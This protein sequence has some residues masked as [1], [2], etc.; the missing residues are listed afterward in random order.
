MNKSNKRK[1]EGGKE[2]NWAKFTVID[3]DIQQ[4]ENSYLTERKRIREKK[5]KENDDENE[6]EK[7]NNIKE[8]EESESLKH[9]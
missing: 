5:S 6:D 4:D 2:E 1:E 9:N 7:D 3:I 8:T